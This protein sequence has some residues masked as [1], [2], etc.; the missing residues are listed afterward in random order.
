MACSWHIQKA[1]SACLKGWKRHSQKLAVPLS[2]GLDLIAP[3]G[4]CGKGLDCAERKEATTG[5]G[6]QGEAVAPHAPGL[7]RQGAA[8]QAGRERA[9]QAAQCALGL[10]CSGVRKGAVKRAI[11]P[12]TSNLPDAATLALMLPWP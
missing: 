11:W 6:G 10:V 7:A 1:R 8:W 4:L 3:A 5:S 9:L 2:F 12:R